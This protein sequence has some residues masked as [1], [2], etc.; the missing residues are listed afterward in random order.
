VS[1]KEKLPC[2]EVEIKFKDECGIY[3]SHLGADDEN[4]AFMQ[5]ISNHPDKNAESY[6]CKKL[7]YTYQEFLDKLDSRRLD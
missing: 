4:S 2:Y 7:D 5:S 3:I 1:D 6:S